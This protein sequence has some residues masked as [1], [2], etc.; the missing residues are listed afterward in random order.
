MPMI[1]T[2]ETEA[3]EATLEVHLDSVKVTSSL[4]DIELVNAQLLRIHG[5]LPSPLQWNAP[6]IWEIGVS[7][8]Q[9]VLYLL[10]DHV[11]MFTDLIK[12]WTS[13]PPSDYLR[14]VPVNYVFKIDCRGGDSHG[15]Y[16]LHT[17][18]NDNNVIDR[19]LVKE[20]NGTRRNSAV[21]P[22][23]TVRKQCSP[24]LGLT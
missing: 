6:R 15:G 5:A 1:A 3:Y 7:L 17:Y 19:P 21:C 20:D 13:G 4:N 8:R 10:R 2:A 14:W 9:P 11:N 18:V 16:E 22:P 23:L 24:C 12:D